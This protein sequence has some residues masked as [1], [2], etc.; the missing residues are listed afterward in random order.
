MQPRMWQ[1]FFN[2]HLKITPRLHIARY[3]VLIVE[4]FMHFSLLTEFT[5]RNW[6]LSENDKKLNKT[7]PWFS[8]FTAVL[9]SP[10]RRAPS[11]AF[12]CVYT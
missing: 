3:A 11:S 5:A 2:G 6:D 8:Y 7:F 9:L 4:M 1:K 10:L 12:P